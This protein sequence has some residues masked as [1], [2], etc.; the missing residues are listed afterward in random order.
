M[1]PVRQGKQLAHGQERSRS[2][3]VGGAEVRCPGR[4]ETAT[5]EGYK[6]W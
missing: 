2:D 3:I 4:G 6:L 1:K 5:D